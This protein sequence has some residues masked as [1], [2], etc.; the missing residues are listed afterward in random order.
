MS[1]SNNASADY[2]LR[3]LWTL[4][5]WI[6]DTKG[7]AA[8]EEVARIAGIQ[9]SDFDGSSVWIS[10]E[11]LERILAQAYELA[12]DEATFKAAFH[13]RFKESFGAFRY[14]AWALSPQK[15]CEQAA[16]M[17]NPT[18]TKVGT[19]EV[20][21]S[22]PSSFRLR[23]RSTKPESRLTCLSRQVPWA[24]GPAMWD[25]PPAQLEEH[26]CMA[27]GNAYCEYALR[28]FE[29]SSVLPPL[30]GGLVGA[31]AAVPFVF[32]GEWG[33][34]VA[35]PALFATLGYLVDVRKKSKANLAYASELNNVMRDLGAAEAETRA[36]IVGLHQRQRDWTRLMEQQ[37][38][39]RTK[40][41]EKVV[42]GINGL[43]Q[44]RASTI[45][46]FSH[47]LRNPLFVVRGNAQ[48]LRDRITEGEDGEAIRDMDVAA[49]QIEAMLS[50]LM[51]VATKDA[52]WVKLAPKPLQVAPM[53][54][55]LRRR[56]KAL[57]HGREIKVSVFSTRD[58]PEELVTDQLVFDRVVDNL[59]TNAAKYTDKGS[60]LV[61]ISGTPAAG[62]DPA[63][64]TMKLSDTGRGIPPNKLESIFKPRSADEPP[65]GP[66]SYGVGLSS[67]VRLLAQVGG[68]IDVMSKV[69][70]GTTVWAHLPLEAREEKIT[71]GEDSFDELISRVVR[72]RKAEGV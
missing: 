23:Y 14:M 25:L 56:L 16:K 35:L 32:H 37:V 30:V 21:E 8:L 43:Q 66:N 40:T 6:E 52:G 53:V 38:T 55:I 59:L 60:I 46:G 70:V 62:D 48:Y 42:E 58:A 67:V 49:G 41:L 36:E 39:E 61:E 64:F 13:H 10:H 71:P 27:R 24:L 7:R 15:I 63:F 57:V 4:A 33:A 9:A 31:L 17:S 47:D 45:R 72:I 1:D 12:G 20:L 18:V 51:E 2:S 69:G 22:T 11:Q 54:D 19:F 65:S 29:P 68:R 3:I 50:Q 44:N 5:R 26:A 34:S 28:W